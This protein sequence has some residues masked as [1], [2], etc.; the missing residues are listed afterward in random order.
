LGFNLNGTSPTCKYA[1]T[2]VLLY[3]SNASLPFGHKYTKPPKNYNLL[4]V[5][6]YMY[7]TTFFCWNICYSQCSI[8]SSVP[9]DYH[10]VRGWENTNDGG[11]II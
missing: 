6:T 2:C 1:I 5:K 3:M 10:I 8:S 7:Q 4:G 11:Y 9:F